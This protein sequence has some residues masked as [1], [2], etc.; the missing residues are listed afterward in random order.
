MWLGR[1]LTLVTVALWVIVWHRWQ[2]LSPNP[3]L[4]YRR[5]ISMADYAVWLPKVLAWLCVCS[6]ENCCGK[7]ALYCEAPQGEHF[8]IS[9]AHFLH[10]EIITAMESLIATAA[11]AGFRLLVLL[12]LESEQGDKKEIWLIYF[13]FYPATLHKVPDHLNRCATY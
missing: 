10:P 8:S 6:Q 7:L 9:V 1:H 2:M 12:C 13:H 11:A 5:H 3:A 4:T